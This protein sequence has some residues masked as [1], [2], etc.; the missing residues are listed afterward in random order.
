MKKIYSKIALF[1]MIVVSAF[2]LTGCFGTTNISNKINDIINGGTTQNNGTTTTRPVSKDSIYQTAVEL[3]ENA[4]KSEIAEAYV[5]C[6]VTVFVMNANGQNVSFGSG[7]CVYSGGYIATNYH[8][9][10]SVLDYSTYSLKIYLNDGI[11]SY[12]AN[13]L[14]ADKTLDVAIIQSSNGDIPFVKMMDRT[15][16]P[17]KNNELKLLEEVI[18]IGTPI[19][20]SLQNTCTFGYVSGLQRYSYASENVY[21]NLIQHTASI[22]NGNSG[23]PLFDLNGNLIGLNTLGSSEGNELYFSVSIYPIIKVLPKVVELNEKTVPETYSLPKLGISL[24]DRFINT[25]YSSTTFSGK[26]IY[27]SQVSS[28]TSNLMR[29]DVITKLTYNSQEYTID[30]RNDIIY[31]I[32]TLQSGNVVSVTLTRNNAQKTVE[33]TLA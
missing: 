2:C 10:S 7:V 6:T 18:A 29:G 19:D 21:E 12:N 30:C 27:V 22:S 31:A 32:M 25:I 17:A 15:I 24:T 3:N 20:F 33:L 26:G 5:N 28:S 9:V 1:I 8:V 4:T 13:V 14:W 11:T 23:G 16:N